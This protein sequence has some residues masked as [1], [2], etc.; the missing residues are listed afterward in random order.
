MKTL[1]EI[2]TEKIISL[3]HYPPDKKEPILPQLMFMVFNEEDKGAY[4]LGLSDNQRDDLQKEILAMLHYT[5]RQVKAMLYLEEEELEEAAARDL[6]AAQTEEEIRQVL[7]VD[8]LM[9]AMEQGS[10]PDD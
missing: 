6:Q 10:I 9:S 4:E 5:D 7:I 3:R 8:L 2:A 1:L